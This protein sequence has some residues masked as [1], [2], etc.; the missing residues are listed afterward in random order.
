M[1]FI[2][3]VII[4]FIIFIIVNF[5]SINIGSIIGVGSYESGIV[6]SAISFLCSIVVICTLVIIDAIKK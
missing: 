3:Y 5:L 1:K 2:A 4:G 6:V